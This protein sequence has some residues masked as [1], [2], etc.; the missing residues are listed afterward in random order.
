MTTE[1]ILTLMDESLEKGWSM[2]LSNKCMVDGERFRQMIDDIRR[3]LPGEI[4]QAR[5]IAAD[6][7]DIIAAARQEAD[8]IIAKAEIKANQMVEEHEITQRARAQAKE[9]M[10]QV[11]QKSTEQMRAAVEFS[12]N[13]LQVVEDCV[14][15]NLKQLHEAKDVIKKSRKSANN[16]L[17]IQID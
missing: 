4:K 5:M 10:H 11:Q 6:R 13:V 8:H 2:P 17:N 15:A 9:Y 16:S 1:E 3:S 7:A 14:S 12:D